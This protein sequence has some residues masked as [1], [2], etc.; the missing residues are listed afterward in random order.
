[1]QKI[2]KLPAP[3]Q[4]SHVLFQITGALRNLANDENIYEDFISSGAISELCQSIELFTLD[5][6]VVSNIS[7]IFSVISTDAQCCESI[8]EFENIF[9][10]FVALFEKYPGKPDMI[11]RLGYTLG[12]LVAL[13]DYARY[14]FYNARNSLQC[15]I[16]VIEV[17]I[18]KDLKQTQQKDGSATFEDVIIKMIRII[19]NVSMNSDVGHELLTNHGLKL[20]DIFI[21]L[22]SR[23][24][25]PESEELILSI[26]STLNNLSYYFTTDSETN[27]FFKKQTELCEE[28]RKIAGVENREC[29]T[30]ALRVLGNLTRAKASREF[31]IESHCLEQ[32][33]KF[34]DH[35]KSNKGAYMGFV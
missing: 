15:L 19:A 8:V 34:L 5:M 3:E 7:R 6:D 24:K 13:F 28:L 12:N 22:L 20:I 27:P 14:K 9:V 32:L 17:Y 2:E 29:V 35:G 25:G 30:E 16:N 11:V 4:I 33:I 18:E 23:K 21:L 1:M 26:L 31:V 10:V